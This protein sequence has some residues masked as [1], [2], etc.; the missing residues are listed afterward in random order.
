MTTS[1]PQAISGAATALEPSDQFDFGENWKSFS[2]TALQ[3][4]RVDAARAAFRGLTADIDLKG[5]SFLDIGFGQGLG[6]CL[7]QEAGAAVCACDINPKCVEALDVTARWFPAFDPSALSLTVGSIL[8]PATVRDLRA[9]PRARDGGF[10][11]VH[12]WGV[13]HHTGNMRLA[14][15]HA[16]SLVRPG[17]HFIVAIYN[18]HWSSPAWRLIKHGYVTSPAPARRLLLGL[19]S[20]AIYL[21]KFA[22]TGRNPLR[23]ERGMDFWHD[24][25]DWVGGYPYEHASIRELASMVTA[26]GFALQKAIPAT[27]PTGCNQF[28]FR[29]SG[30]SAR[31]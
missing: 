27:V 5:S 9:H 8:N 16:T 28:V 3:A 4:G 12:S 23:Q 18:T 21:A 22:A 26:R 20:P 7:A 25:V 2:G 15:D 19:L 17:G 11:V 1:L 10:D 29:K 24:V 6:V 13:L 14:L 31:G 30:G